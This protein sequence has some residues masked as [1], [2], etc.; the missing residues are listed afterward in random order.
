M[1]VGCYVNDIQRVSSDGFAVDTLERNTTSF[2]MISLRTAI[3]AYFSTFKS[4]RH[5]FNILIDP[6]DSSSDQEEIDYQYSS[7][8]IENYAETIVHF[9]HFIEL[10]CKEILRNEHELLVLNINNKHELLLKL[11]NKED[12]PKTDLEGL[13]T[14]EFSTTFDRLCELIKAGN[15]DT[16]YNFL[17]EKNNK[18]TLQEL[19]KMRNK[20]WHRGTFVLRYNAMDSFIGKHLLPIIAQITSLPEY[21]S[22][23][24]R[25]MF[26][27][28]HL[29]VNP[30]TEII[31]E[32]SKDNYDI[33]KVAFLK[34]MGRSA[35]NNPLNYTFKFINEEIVNR[36]QR[37]AQ[38]EVNGGRTAQGVH[39]NSCPVCGVDSLVTY[40][41]SDG[42]MNEDGTYNSY[43]T[44]VWYIKCHCCSFELHKDGL[45]NPKEY[46]Y[47]LPDYW[48]SYT[49]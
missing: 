46:G 16:R 26:K 6:N 44:F 30:I 8:Y 32:C 15:F 48:Y 36:S 24:K 41:D 21:E 9:Q 11:L 47:D 10:V 2:A 35:Y 17:I 33:S 39:V 49:H 38:A 1:E 43:W 4:T 28:L 22:L 45:K 5:Y 19:N 31:N 3:K 23:S 37:I 13:R 40:E 12:V 42:D 34:E 20:I 7:N 27:P 25:W 18:I 29:G 14:T